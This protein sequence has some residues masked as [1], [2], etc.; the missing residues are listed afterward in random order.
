MHVGYTT[1]MCR[2]AGQLLHVYI[3]VYFCSW[4]EE[5]FA[6]AADWVW[7]AALLPVGLS[8]HRDTHT[9]VIVIISGV[10]PKI[11]YL[12]PFQACRDPFC[13]LPLPLCAVACS[14]AA[15]P[16]HWEDG[17]A[18]P[19]SREPLISPVLPIRAIAPCKAYLIS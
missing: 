12:G 8:A 7:L 11:S 18:L 15:G 4:P 19:P 1:H 6:L 3:H 14:C 10:A 9:L 16:R 17:H 2:L 5:E 13:S